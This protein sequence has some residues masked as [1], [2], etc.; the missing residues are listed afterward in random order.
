MFETLLCK[1]AN[2]SSIRLKIYELIQNHLNVILI[3]VKI[4]HADKG[5]LWCQRKF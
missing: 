2:R 1:Q 4:V 5:K 3:K